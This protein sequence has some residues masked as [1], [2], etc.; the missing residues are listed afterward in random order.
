VAAVADARLA[1]GHNDLSASIAGVDKALQDVGPNAAGL[2][3]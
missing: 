1:L 2:K 3:T